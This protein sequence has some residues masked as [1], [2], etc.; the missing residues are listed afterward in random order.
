MFFRVFPTFICAKYGLP[1]LFAV[2]YSYPFG[3]DVGD[4]QA[5]MVAISVGTINFLN[6]MGNA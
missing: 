4:W 3:N 6:P 5:D 1:N 2:R